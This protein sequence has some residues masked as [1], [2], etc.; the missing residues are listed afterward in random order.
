MLLLG[1][2]G[3]NNLALRAEKT[4]NGYKKNFMYFMVNFCV[5][6]NGYKKTKHGNTGIFIRW[7]SRWDL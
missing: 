1:L 4:V 7:N 5:V 2:K 6:V 3:Q